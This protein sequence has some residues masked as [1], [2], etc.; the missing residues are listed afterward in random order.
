MTDL[1]ENC[2]DMYND[3]FHRYKLCKGYDEFLA[4]SRSLL[5]CW[6]KWNCECYITRMALCCSTI[7]T[8]S[9][10]FRT[11]KITRKFM[12]RYLCAT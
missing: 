8:G 7:L 6:Y 12:V 5:S 2:D 10:L 1:T 4:L 3:L 9:L 11:S